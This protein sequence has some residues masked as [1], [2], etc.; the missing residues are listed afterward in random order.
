[1][2]LSFSDENNL[3][4]FIVEFSH[5]KLFWWGLVDLRA[6]ARPIQ[7]GLVSIFML[8]TIRTL[9]KHCEELCLPQYGSFLVKRITESGKDFRP[10]SF[11]N[12]RRCSYHWRGYGPRD[13]ACMRFDGSLCTEN[14]VQEE[15]VLKESS[16]NVEDNYTN[17]NNGNS[18]YNHIERINNRDINYNT[19]EIDHYNN[20]SE[21]H[22]EIMLR[23]L[24]LAQNHQE[25]LE[26]RKK[27]E[28][29]KEIKSKQLKLFKKF[30][31]LSKKGIVSVF[32]LLFNLL[33]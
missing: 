25:Q 3:K 28:S 13:C 24:E 23:N 12:N 9:L 29:K 20:N 30:H 18:R 19:N 11:M 15:V 4:R 8:H 33:L 22:W 5:T 10:V 1:M 21:P 17:N 7:G 26:G 6:Y 16:S 32:Y 2:E 31:E 14:N 27:T